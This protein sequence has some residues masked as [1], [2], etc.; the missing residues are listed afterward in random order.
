MAIF[1][2]H[3]IILYFTGLGRLYT[4]FGLLGRMAFSL[5][6]M[7]TSL[8]KQRKFIVENAHDQRVISHW[9]RREIAIV[10]GS[11]FNKAMYK[12]MP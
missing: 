1:S 12:K 6:I 9:T 7:L 10:N 8:Q 4:D 5:L 3:Y 2:K 11:G